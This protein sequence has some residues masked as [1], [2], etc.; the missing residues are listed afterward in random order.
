MKGTFDLNLL[1]VIAAL[2]ETRSVTRAAQK[3]KMSQPGLSSA[4][5]RLRQQFGDP[6]FVR[7]AGGMQPTA[8]GLELADEARAMLHRI[9]EKVLKAPFFVAAEAK[10]E[11]RF[12]MQDVGEMVFLPTLVEAFRSLA[13]H[14][15]FQAASYSPRE[16][17]V[18]MEAGQ[19]D[20]ALGYL[21][22]LR[23]SAFL[24]QR[25]MLHGFSC[26]LRAGHPVASHLTKAAFSELEHVVVE[27][28]TRSQELVDN[29]LDRR[30]IVRKVRLRSTHFLTLPIIVASTDMIATVPTPVGRVFAGTD[31]VVVVAPPYQIPKFPIQQHWHRRY[32][33]DP[34]NRWLREQVALLFG[35]G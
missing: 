24:K 15:T 12:A 28:P 10:T 25:L 21:P 7:A 17:E 23:S 26:I 33:Q 6:L 32:D 27:S 20:L 34:R 1:A 16:L 22:D 18:A 11:F 30:N 14:A 4:L 5:V 2:D 13:P 31:R 8:R 3:L 29:Y 19:V 35:R 9:H